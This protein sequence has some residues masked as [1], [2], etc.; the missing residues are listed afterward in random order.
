M[1]P[2]AVAIWSQDLEPNKR[3]MYTVENDIRI[4]G[5]SLAAQLK[6]N[7]GRTVVEVLIKIPEDYDIGE[8][9][10]DDKGEQ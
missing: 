3:N 10:T 9:P 4:T 7:S 8:I 2:V 6:D 1:A 5:A